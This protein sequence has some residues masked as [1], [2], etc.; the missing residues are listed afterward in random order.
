MKFGFSNINKPTPA[1]MVKLGVSLVAVSTF[2]AGYGITTQ[3][4]WMGYTGLAIGA[5]GT[6]L[7][8]MF[9]D[10]KAQ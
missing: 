10:E 5:L 7:A 4:P 2:I 1:K 6:L 8:N 9:S 3:T